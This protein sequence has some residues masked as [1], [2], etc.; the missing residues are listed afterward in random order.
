MVPVPWL[1]LIT[2]TWGIQDGGQK[3]GGVWIDRMACPHLVTLR[4]HKTMYCKACSPSYEGSTRIRDSYREERDHSL[5]V[6]VSKRL[7]CPSTRER[8]TRARQVNPGESLTAHVAGSKLPASCVLLPP[9]C[10]DSCLD[11]QTDSRFELYQWGRDSTIAL[12]YML[13][14]FNKY[15]FYIIDLIV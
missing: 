8:R 3:Q 6:Y 10:R 4:N 1:A 14:I 7:G 9:M 15:F 2:V 5:V 11:R 12:A 13:M